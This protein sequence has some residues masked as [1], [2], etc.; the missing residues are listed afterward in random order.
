MLLLVQLGLLG[1][2]VLHGVGVGAGAGRHTTHH[3]GRI[4]LRTGA[5]DAH[6]SDHMLGHGAGRCA[7]L[8][9]IVRHAWGHARVAR[10]A[11]RVRRE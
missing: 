1:V 10:R 7:G 4:D 3:G 9:W 8:T 6:V 11:A 2:E 5:G